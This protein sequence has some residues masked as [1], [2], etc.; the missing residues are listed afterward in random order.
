MDE[1]RPIDGIT[2]E[3]VDG[4]WLALDYPEN[5]TIRIDARLL[6]RILVDDDDVLLTIG[7]TTVALTITR[8]VGGA[9]DIAERL[10]P[11]TRSA[12]ITQAEVYEDA[13]RRLEA[14]NSRESY[15][16][17]PALFFGSEGVYASDEILY[18]GDFRC[19]ISDVERY[20]AL[21]AVIPLPNG[22]G[23]QAALAMLVVAARQR[24]EDL[25]VLSRRI[26]DYET[27]VAKALVA[28]QTS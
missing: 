22:G 7:E 6:D 3:R 2:K 23:M 14:A 8:G 24:R 10:F 12:P 27:R 9:R 21:G 11:Y 17:E 20:E 1:E 19:L 13:K 5:P 26:A 28:N 18:I 16:A 4:A 15:R 25:T